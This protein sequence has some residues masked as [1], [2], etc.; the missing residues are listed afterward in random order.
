[1]AW[2][3][4]PRACS[5]S[6]ASRRWRRSA[7]VNHLIEVHGYRRIAFIRGPATHPGAQERYQGYVEALTQHGL[8]FDPRLVS[9]YLSVWLSK[10]AEA[11]THRLLDEQPAGLEAIVAADD[12]LALGALS[13]L[14]TRY[15]R[16]PDE[17]ANLGATTLPLTTVQPPFYALGF[18]AVELLLA[19]IRG[20]PAPEVVTLPTELVVRRSCGCFSEAMRQLAPGPGAR[21]VEVGVSVT[22]AAQREHLIT[23][24]RQALTP[25]TAAFSPEWAEQ[26]Q[27]T[28]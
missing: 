23:Q 2:S 14:Q 1:M 4:G 9:P 25:S 12:T 17:L 5:D 16:V 18:R 20:E 10:E 13:A 19:Q 24:M 8:P 21:P 3:F 28:E 22:R 11:M 27:L 26:R 15:I 7:A 6:W